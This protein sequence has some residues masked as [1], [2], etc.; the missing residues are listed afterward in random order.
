MNTLINI[1]GAVLLGL[2]AAYIIRGKSHA[3]RINEYFCNAIR[4]YALTNEDDARVA[5]VTAAKVA[6]KK[7]RISMVKY[8]RD[9]ASDIKQMNENDSKLKPLTDKFIKSSIDLAE[10]ISSREWTISDI[11]KQKEKLKNINADYLV[12]LD[13]ADPKIFAKKHPQFFK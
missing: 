9:M 10:E 13:N 2:F 6:T 1:I 4:V 11:H 8:L 7:Q 3:K 12:A 5:I